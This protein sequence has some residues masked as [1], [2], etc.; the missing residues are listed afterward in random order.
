MIDSERKFTLLLVD[1]N[2]TNLLL[3]VKIIEFDLPEVRVLTASSALKGLQL[4]EQEQIDGAF[5]DVHM[6]QLDGLDMCRQLRVNPRTAAIPLVLMTAH[7]ASP[8]IR[9]EGLEVGAY[10]FISQPI[11]N[12]EMLARIKV[13]LRLCESEKCSTE[14]NQQLQHRLN[15]QEERLRW[16]RGLLISGNGPLAEL[17]PKLLRHLADELPDPARIDD[18]LFFEQLIIEFPHPWRR[19]LL[20]LS[21]LDSIPSSLAQKIGEIDDVAAVFEYLSRHQL[22]SVIV[23]GEEN[24]FSFKPQIVE[25]LR[26]KGQQNLSV[27]ERQQVYLVAADWY[28]QGKDYSAALGILISSGEYAA[29]SQLLSQVGFV[30]LDHNYPSRIAPLLEKIPLAQVKGCP[31][32]A[33]FRACNDI[34]NQS[35]SAVG[36]LSSA[37]QQ[38]QARGDLRGELLVLSQEFCQA[39]FINGDFL[40]LGDRLP[41]F[42]QLAKDLSPELEAVERLK[43]AFSFGL[44]EL[45]FMEELSTVDLILKDSLAEAQ[46]LN[47]FDQ[48]LE[49]N[50]LRAF[51]ALRLGRYLVSR[52]AM[53]H[54]LRLAAERSA[55]PHCLWLQTIA[56]VLLRDSGNFAG[57]QRQQSTFMKFQRHGPQQQRVISSL[58]SY[59][60]VTLLLARGQKQAAT[61]VLD[62]AMQEG[63]TANSLY[64][65][66]RFLQLRGWIRALSGEE[67]AARNDLEAGLKNLNSVNVGLFNLENLLFAGGTC[68]ALADFVAAEKYLT[69]GLAGSEKYQEE[70]FRSGFLVWLAVTQHKLG[71]V[72]SATQNLT[73]FIELFQR[74]RLNFFWGFTPDLIKNL[75]PLISQHEQRMLLKPLLE[76]QLLCSLDGD[77]NQIPLLEICCLGKF[78]L[79]LEQKTFVLSQ[80]G[81]ASRQIFA[82]LVVAPN[83]KL[84]IELMMGILWPESSSHKAR[85]SFDTA[86][87]RLRKA[88]E[89]CFGQR[90][91]QDYLVLEKGMLSLRNVQVDSILFTQTMGS[92]RYHM[93]RDDFWQAE[94]TLWKMDRF[95]G[96]AFLSGYDLDGDFSLQ[97]EQLTQLRLEQ[98]GV[99]A[100]LLQQRQQ[101]DEAIRLL[102]QGLLLDSTHDPIIRQLLFIFRQQNDIYSADRLLE[103]YRDALQGEEYDAEE[104]DE[105]IEI[106]ST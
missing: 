91:R 51:Y 104:I 85:N 64:L 17:D 15:E 7:I 63:G 16:I 34:Y 70:R 74:H 2:P 78:Q 38:F 31:W 27:A 53:E 80:V 84:S 61:E 105:L 99:L 10:D 94:H 59:Y 98:L 79:R 25:V 44:V 72:E 30:L 4:V 8:E 55:L 62:L 86:H 29:V 24:H 96:G 19:T 100:R 13:M 88:L 56:C 39:F 26:E 11:S 28:C 40:P 32:I 45:F 81:Q 77:G 22:S 43:V 89:R 21:L 83:C 48:Q 41:R 35:S 20:K 54:G 69:L 102:Q 18:Q 57:L 76:E 3:L 101:L 50:L 6:P 103:K 90:V 71:K 82:L 47:L 42:R 75:L 92:V 93:Q 9:A 87:S 68:Y 14:S 58:I 49:L 67:I 46:Q 1:D 52:T 65:Y 60:T 33:L 23:V 97:R 36:W 5:I 12:V 37:Y 106:L 95:W 66:S 73:D